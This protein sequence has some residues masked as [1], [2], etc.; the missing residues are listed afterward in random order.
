M[1][2]LILMGKRKMLFRMPKVIAKLN[3]TNHIKAR[4]SIQETFNQSN[5]HKTAN[6]NAIQDFIL[7]PSANK[8][9]SI[10]VPTNYIHFLPL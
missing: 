3:N 9:K 10:A 1:A 8:L 7:S 2:L 5:K 6:M 4:E